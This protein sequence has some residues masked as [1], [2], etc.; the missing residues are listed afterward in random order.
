MFYSS[1]IYFPDVVIQKIYSHWR[2]YFEQYKNISIVTKMETVITP[3]LRRYLFSI[4]DDMEEYS[5]DW[6]M[7]ID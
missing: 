5:C 2:V 6:T 7:T 3:K 1:L 4:A